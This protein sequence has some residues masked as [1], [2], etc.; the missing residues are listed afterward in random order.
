MHVEA[1]PN[2][3]IRHAT[4][5][6]N[7]MIAAPWGNLAWRRMAMVKFSWHLD[8]Q[9]ARI[10]RRI[11][12]AWF[13]GVPVYYAVDTTPPPLRSRVIT[14]RLHALRYTVRH[15]RSVLRYDLHSDPFTG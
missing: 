10:A 14:N 11:G 15:G 3:R 7:A 4:A 8:Q 6:L 2:R 13:A 5:Y 12:R 9:S 1:V